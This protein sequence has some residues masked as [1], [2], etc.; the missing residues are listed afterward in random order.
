MEEK[1]YRLPKEF[2]NKWL[3]AL[4][5]GE[6]VQGQGQLYSAVHNSYCCLGVA[7]RIAGESLKEMDGQTFITESFEGY[8]EELVNRNPDDL[9]EP[10]F[11]TTL[12]N[13][14]DGGDYNFGSIADFIEQ[15]TELY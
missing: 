1:K 5:S 9:E 11:C 6:Y 4:R 15:N 14:N 10:R 3:T 8:P 7:A 2:A 12:A 13:L